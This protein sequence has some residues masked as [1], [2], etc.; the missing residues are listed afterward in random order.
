LADGLDDGYQKAEV[1]MNLKL[2]IL[3]WGSVLIVF[4]GSGKSWAGPTRPPLAVMTLADGTAIV[5]DEGQRV[6]GIR[7][8]VFGENDQY[9]YLAPPLNHLEYDSAFYRGNAKVGLKAKYDLSGYKLKVH[10]VMTPLED[11]RVNS[12]QASV[13]FPYA[14]WAGMP[15]KLRTSNGIIPI[16]TEKDNMVAES[17]DSS[18][19]LG[20]SNAHSG[21]SVSFDSSD[22]KAHLQDYRKFTPDLKVFL[23]LLDSGE[24]PWV[25]KKGEPRTFDYILTFNR[26]LASYPLEKAYRISKGFVGDWQGTEDFKYPP[27][28][29]V[30]R[31]RIALSISK[32]NKGIFSA[33]LS[34]PDSNKAFTV[35]EGVTVKGPIFRG[36]DFNGG[37]VEL[38]L[39]KKADEMTGQISWGDYKVPLQLKRGF[40]FLTP[41]LDQQGIPV[42]QYAYEQPVE[43]GDGWKVGDLRHVGVDTAKTEEGIKRILKGDYPNIDSVVLVK[44]GKIVLDEYFQAYAATDE[45]PICSATK[46]ILGTLFGLAHDQGLM[47]PGDKLY[48]NYPSYRE[49]KG[50][51]PRKNKIT[52]GMVLSLTAGFGCGDFENNYQCLRELEK[53]PDWLDFSLSQPLVNDPGKTFSYNST[54]VIPLEDLIVRKSGLAF[55]DYAQKYLFDPLGIQDNHWLQ[56]P[57]GIVMAGYGLWMKPRDMAKIGYLYINHGKWNENNVLSEKWI[58]DAMNVH[59]PNVDVG[60][61]YGYLWWQEHM[62]CRDHLIKVVYAVGFGGQYI[63]IVPEEKIVCVMTGNNFENNSRFALE[64]DWFKRYI[65]AAL[66]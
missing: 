40:S 17:T 61:D 39:N 64:N 3:A 53:S 33:S 47:N 50:W 43:M 38:R 24:K 15:Y 34:Y 28:F 62:P 57:R 32:N 52:L 8:E 42:T 11:I 16:N 25:W 4:S 27:G 18:L 49:K 7:P 12:A 6:C 44:D 56:G 10:Y 48:D 66:N 13:Y 26:E 20:P 1:F 55:S 45:H 51:D 30:E 21:L 65:L 35:L 31:F 37:N 58:E 14:Q 22:L 29:D 9:W 23:C 59:A 5:F 63:F 46:S 36:V 60:Q 41:R 54:C 19:S 2:K